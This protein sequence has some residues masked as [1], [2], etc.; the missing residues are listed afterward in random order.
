MVAGYSLET[1]EIYSQTPV[2][3]PP[4]PPTP[5]PTALTEPAEQKIKSNNKK[6]SLHEKKKSLLMSHLQVL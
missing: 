4:L 1:A 6:T 5:D 2:G 3:H